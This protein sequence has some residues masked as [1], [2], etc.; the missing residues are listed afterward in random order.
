MNTKK[1]II[2]IIIAG[3]ILLAV[4]LLTIY[5]QNIFKLINIIST[6]GSIAS[7]T[8]IAIAYTQIISV[9]KISESSNIAI[10]SAISE[11]VKSFS[12]S[13][14]SRSV[15]LVQEIQSLLRGD[16]MESSL[17]RMK[18]LKSMIIQIKH[19]EI[20]KEKYDFEEYKKSLT[21]L[22][23][24]MANINALLIKHKTGV[25]IQKINNNL[26]DIST[27]LNELENIIKYN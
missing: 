9:K 4:L 26:E 17:L 11:L 13:D 3:G 19:V 2:Q 21:N 25:N 14:L 18:D 24:D 10:Q 12:I 27:F 6:V 7:L 15:K 22:N 1:I 8:G 16:K 5:Y 23:I 20:L